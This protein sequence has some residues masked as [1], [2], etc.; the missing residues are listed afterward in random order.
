MCDFLLR[1]PWAKGHLLEFEG[2]LLEG[3]LYGGGVSVFIELLFLYTH[4]RW[5]F[6]WC[7]CRRV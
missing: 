2:G 7:V 6:V 4:G 1:R 5:W 3:L